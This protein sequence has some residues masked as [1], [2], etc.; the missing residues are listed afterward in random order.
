MKTTMLL[1]AGMLTAP[2]CPANESTLHEKTSSSESIF[3]WQQEAP[4]RAPD[5]E[6]FFPD[7]TEG[8]K[9]LDALW[10]AKDKDNRSD[11]EILNTVHNGLRCT[12][13]HRTNIIRWI[14]SKYI[15]GKSPQHPYAIEIMYHAA[16]FSGD[17]ADPYGTRHY[18]VYFGLSVTKPK[19][20]A[21]LRTL[22]ELCMRID[23]PNDLGRVAWGAKSQQ[24]EL[25][26][27][28][29]PYFDSDDAAVRAK[30]EICQ[31]IFQ[32]KLKAFEW[33]AQQAKE[34]AEKEYTG[35][36]PEIKEALLSGDTIKRKEILKLI[37]A[38]RLTLIMDDSF[39][40][41]F[42]A[43]A[44]DPDA[45]V[46]NST[47]KLIGGYWIWRAKSQNP[48]AIELVLTLSKDKNREVRYNSVYYGL[49]TVRE[50]DEEVIRRLL[51]MAFTDREHNLY[52]RITWGLKHDRK[53]TAKIL[54]EYIN[55]SNPTHSKQAREIYK[56]MTGKDYAPETISELQQKHE[57]DYAP[58][59]VSELQQKYE[60]AYYLETAKG[61][62]KQ[63]AALY[64]AISEAE[65]TAENKTAIKQSLLRLLHIAT[66]RKHE[67]TIK[68]CHEKLL[69]KTDTTIQELVD[70]TKTGGTIYIPAGKYEGTVVLNKNM[71]LKGA[72]RETCILE[73]TS[74]KPLIHVPK[75][76]T[77]EIETLTL[78]SQRETSE[79]TDPPG[80]TV[81][82]Q[83]ATVTVRDCNLVALGGSK[84]AP[85][86]VFIQGFSKVQLLDCHFKGFEYPI[87]Y[88]EGSEGMVKG[89]IVQ[90][91][92]HCGIMSHS[93]TEVT[94]EGN[95][96]T[97]SAYHGVRSTGGTI[98]VK[99]N[100]IVANRNRGIYLGNKTTHGEIS[101]NAIIENGTGISAFA[102]ADV[103]IGNNVILGNGFSGID[104]RT[105][106][107]IQVKNNIIADN[108][109]TGFAVFEA[110][111]NKFKVGKNTFWNNGTPSTDFDLPSST[112]EADPQ[113]ADPD[114]G[115]FSVGNSKVKSAKHGLTN[116]DAISTLWKKYEELTK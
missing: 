73:A 23:D 114:S 68:E 102:S 110:G 24:E 101:N 64:K 71:T 115:N 55:G 4:Y 109:K 89:C 82:A 60:K 107:K 18:A 100:L 8:G 78:K 79:R 116:P 106:G 10:E 77:V 31:Q 42:A 69:Q 40:N 72:D 90:N 112:L 57:K 28:L 83:D 37:R 25:I 32:G 65:P 91:P 2:L 46:R 48:D 59:T 96:V 111:S 11:E 43:C 35:Q 58:E 70:A 49:S 41:A 52:G 94:I 1:I 88:G 30:A 26:K 84:R 75:K 29:Q 104:T 56:D 51:E 44:K 98:H 22:A 36:L 3:A 53:K 14:G 74:D 20:P 27:Y 12:K 7:D 80:C 99:D 16:D 34:R 50:K 66:V 86:S 17:R 113:F 81:L 108:E 92:G 105:Y 39:L 19:T 33:A 38:K 87:L 47:V 9:T 93:N 13:Q 62:A 85:L 54:N 15:W 67:S 6:L 76:Q 95:I 5:F 63:A 97:G 21:I 45:T 103:E 61:Q